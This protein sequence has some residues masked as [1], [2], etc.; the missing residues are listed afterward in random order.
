MRREL[1]QRGR[2]E[3]AQ[4]RPRMVCSA[5][6]PIQPGDPEVTSCCVTNYPQIIP[7]TLKNNKCVLFHVVLRSKIQK[8]EFSLW[9][10]EL[11]T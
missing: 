7:K 11:K 3:P 9:L 5:W 1:R 8:Q 10:S 6:G 4:N 2:P